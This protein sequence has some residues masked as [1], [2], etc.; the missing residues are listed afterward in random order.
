MKITDVE[1]IPLYLQTE[2]DIADGTQDALVILVHTDEGITGVGEADTSPPIG[3]AIVN[4]PI[5]GD[6]CQGLRKVV[7]GEDPFE[8]E[9]IWN[10]MYM[11][12]YKYG[13][14]GA[15]INVM[16]GIDLALWDIIGKKVGKPA[17]KLLGGA[18]K[19]EVTPYASTLF[20]QDSGDTD[21]M[22][23]EVNQYL[24]EGFRA[25]KFGWGGF[26]ENPEDDYQLMKTARME[27]GEEVKIMVDVGMKWTANTTIQR[28]Q[29][30]REFNPYWFEEPVIADDYEGYREAAEAI[31]STMVVGG[32]EEY[33]RYGFRDLIERGKVDGIQP[34]LARS[35]GYTE[36]RHIA[37]IA[38]SRN[39]PC[40]PHGWSTDILIKAN[41]HFIAAFDCPFLEY[42]VMDSPLRWEVTKNPSRLEDGKVRVPE[43]PGLGI[44]LNEDTLDK[45]G[46]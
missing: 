29:L 11:K 46:S 32:E 16:S 26:G 8:V 7:T 22:K 39:I 12:T 33:T 2:K 41:L 34:D 45:Y 19:K 23:S 20:P 44:E 1:A 21:F 5:S 18:Y 25:I 10:K 31:K 42:C 27:A 15:A 36:S 43:K 13:R 14:K 35:G 6:K 40:I 9:K 30:L 28:A 24:E 4:A 3:E 37:A 38:Q 17:Y